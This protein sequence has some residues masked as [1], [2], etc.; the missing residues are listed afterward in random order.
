M[1]SVNLLLF[2][3]LFSTQ[4][5]WAFPSVFSY[6]DKSDN[7]KVIVSCTEGVNP[8]ADIAAIRKIADNLNC[9]NMTAD[10]Y[11]E[12]LSTK[13]Q[14]R[15]SRNEQVVIQTELG[16]FGNGEDSFPAAD[17]KEVIELQQLQ[18]MYGDKIGASCFSKTLGESHEKLDED[19]RHVLKQPDLE[20]KTNHVPSYLNTKY[21]NQTRNLTA[22]VAS[23]NHADKAESQ[24]S[25]VRLMVD[26]AN[27][28]KSQK[29]PSN[30]FTVSKHGLVY[31]GSDTTIHSGLRYY[32]KEIL[33]SVKENNAIKAFFTDDKSE[34]Y[35][36]SL[37]YKTLQGAVAEGSHVNSYLTKNN[38][39]ADLIKTT[40]SL[41][42]EAA[43]KDDNSIDYNKVSEQMKKLDFTLP[44]TDV[45]TALCEDASK[46]LI[47][48]SRTSDG[49][50][51]MRADKKD[52]FRKKGAALLKGFSFFDGSSEG[53]EDKF[54]RLGLLQQKITSRMVEQLRYSTTQNISSESSDDLKEFVHKKKDSMGRMWCNEQDSSEMDD[55]LSDLIAMD[56][57]KAEMF[58]QTQEEIEKLEAE[59]LESITD[60][61]KVSQIEQEARKAADY[62]QK[63]RDKFEWDINDI[64]NEIA[65]LDSASPDY[66][67]NIDNLTK[68]IELLEVMRADYKEQRDRNLKVKDNAISRLETLH[69]E[70]KK[71]EAE[72]EAK[73]I[74][75]ARNLVGGTG[76]FMSME[77]AVRSSRNL[78]VVSTGKTQ[79]AEEKSYH[80]EEV[81][82]GEVLIVA[83]NPDDKSIIVAPALEVTQSVA[84]TQKETIGIVIENTSNGVNENTPPKVLDDAIVSIEDMVNDSFTS[85]KVLGADKEILDKSRESNEK[86]RNILEPR[87][88]KVRFQE[89]GEYRRVEKDNDIINNF[90]EDHNKKYK[91]IAKQ[92]L[93]K[94]IG[95][96]EALEAKNTIEQSESTEPVS[97][98]KSE[99][100]IKDSPKAVDSSNDV[101]NRLT[102]VLDSKLGTNQIK[103][104]SLSAIDARKNILADRK[105]NKEKSDL[106]KEKTK[107]RNEISE[108]TTKAKKIKNSG[109]KTKRIEEE[110]KSKS[111]GIEKVD[112]EVKSDSGET[113]VASRSLS[114]AFKPVNSNKQYKRGGSPLNR[115]LDSF[116]SRGTASVSSGPAAAVASIIQ[117]RTDGGII[118]NGEFIPSILL[119]RGERRDSFKETKSKVNNL[120]SLGFQGS[121][122]EMVEVINNNDD[123]SSLVPI[124]TL[125][126]FEA[127]SV[128]DKELF[129]QQQFVKF[130]TSDVV[131][132]MK[133]GRKVLFKSRISLSSRRKV[134][135]LN[136]ILDQHT[137]FAE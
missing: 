7:R 42:L 93:I 131:I 41:N 39:I 65:Q 18:I 66:Q 33:V 45:L 97:Q 88:G 126:N 58:L 9:E 105:S 76:G 75:G 74:A 95:P 119:Y 122:F 94:E 121:T 73:E 32:N 90:V 37:L 116:R 28:I 132:K 26:L 127:L 6:T 55:L 115:A 15:Q 51:K 13:Y 60:I 69:D 96:V 49:H 107:I 136:D 81:D 40:S 112:S 92:K 11:C 61:A 137:T 68:N 35:K 4:E 72:I 22:L 111:A 59:H 103:Q 125:E 62:F 89:L 84:K 135:D 71:K 98:S 124:V 87:V 27:L 109:S 1:R 106:T 133:N 52:L 102:K 31:G 63:Q 29:K 50:G 47:D 24:M 5:L 99:S 54:R 80:V 120:K 53:K 20:Y 104:K 77:S 128:N 113:Q 38:I 2:L 3:A 130:N 46:D 56:T 21:I 101:F 30:G 91:V 100:L 117:K 86:V 85:L 34:K 123:K 25:D 10:D 82:H 114:S 8:I 36:G 43:Q 48:N 17:L 118:V 57:E 70:A 64:K 134:S 129:V 12:C 79:G 83:L 108:L 67:K 19:A 14:M 23:A 110:K 16:L 44:M 78:R